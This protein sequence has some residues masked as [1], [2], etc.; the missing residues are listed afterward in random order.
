MWFYWGDKRMCSKYQGEVSFLFFLKYTIICFL[1]ISS[2]F[3][4][5][6]GL[7]NKCCFS[8]AHFRG[9]YSTF[10]QN[11]ICKSCQVCQQ[12]VQKTH[13]WYVF[14]YQFNDSGRK[15]FTFHLYCS[16]NNIIFTNDLNIWQVHENI[17]T[18]R[19]LLS[20]LYSDGGKFTLLY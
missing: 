13:K 20:I 18:C 2:Q 7:K 9:K 1:C 4:L 17:I 11:S 5:Q 3:L 8:F 19:L 6:K 16:N 15:C 14:F 10:L 12:N